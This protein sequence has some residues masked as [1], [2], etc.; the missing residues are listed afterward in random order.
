M[1][2]GNGASRYL[3]EEEKLTLLLLDGYPRCVGPYHPLYG[4]PDMAWDI[5]YGPHFKRTIEAKFGIHPVHNDMAQIMLDWTRWC[6][7]QKDHP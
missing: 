5:A 7:K 6:R 3:T 1:T 2:S 4:W